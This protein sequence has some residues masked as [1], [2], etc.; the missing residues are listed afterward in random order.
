[1]ESTNPI[2]YKSA[3]LLSPHNRITSLLIS[4]SNL[5]KGNTKESTY[6]HHKE[7]STSINTK[8][9]ILN[10]CNDQEDFELHFTLTGSNIEFTRTKHQIESFQKLC[11]E[12]QL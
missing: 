6:F 10:D 1:M 7:R 4:N 2:E 11:D 9:T 12:N 3:A 8:P 5:N